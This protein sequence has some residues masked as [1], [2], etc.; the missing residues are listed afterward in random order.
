MNKENNYYINLMPQT[1][2][3]GGSK[4]TKAIDLSLPNLENL[5]KEEKKAIKEKIL[6]EDQRIS[7][8][9]LPQELR[10]LAENDSHLEKIYLKLGIK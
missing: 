5:N 10:S 6:L 9:L 7:E 1:T 4:K 2:F 8:T 3:R